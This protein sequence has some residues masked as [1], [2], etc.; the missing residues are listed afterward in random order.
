MGGK[1]HIIA[2]MKLNRQHQHDFTTLVFQFHQTPNAV[3]LALC[4]EKSTRV[5]ATSSH[6][7]V[8]FSLFLYAFEIFMPPQT[9]VVYTPQ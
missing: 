4:D 5:T 9:L 7:Y 8:D 6:H 2:I 3:V 1:I